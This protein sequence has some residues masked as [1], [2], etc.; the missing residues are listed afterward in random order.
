M[1]NVDTFK[2]VYWL[3]TPTILKYSLYAGFFVCLSGCQPEDKNTAAENS[4]VVSSEQPN[5]SPQT[6]LLTLDELLNTADF[7][8]ATKQAVLNDDQVSL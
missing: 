7:K 2:T 3:A 1:V 5:V 4:S 6:P 8:R